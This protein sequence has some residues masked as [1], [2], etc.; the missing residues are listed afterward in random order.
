LDESRRRGR[1]D[2]EFELLDTGVLDE[3]RYFDVFIEYAKSSPDDVLIRI[4]AANRGPE[5]AVL[6]LLPTLWFRNTWAW[7][8]PDFAKRQLVLFLREWYMN[9]SGQ[10]P[11]YEFSLDEGE[12]LSPFGVRSLSKV[13]Q[14]RPFVCQAGPPW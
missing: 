1:R 5:P 3:G 13:H 9:P 4:L 14:A 6:P 8:D 11:A 10:L 7:V 2:P 12:F